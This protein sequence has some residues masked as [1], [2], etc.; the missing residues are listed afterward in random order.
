[1]TFY[2]RASNDA[3]D[4]PT[5]AGTF[6]AFELAPT[7]TGSTCT[8]VLTVS[9]RVSGVNT[10]LAQGP[11]A[12]KTSMTVRFVQ[13]NGWM[14]FNTNLGERYAITDSS[15]TSGKPGVGARL[16]AAGSYFTS[17][18]LGAAD[19]T[20]PSSVV[21]SSV[22][23]A[24]FDTR[25]DL[26]WQGAADDTNGSGIA[27]YQV[28]RGGPVLSNTPVENI[29]DT[30][31]TASQAYVYVIYAF[32]FHGNYSAGTT[33]NVTTAPA[34]MR[35]PRKTGVRPLGLYW[36]ASP[37]NIDLQS[38]NL[39]FSLPTVTAQGRGGS[40]VPLRMSY[41]SQNWRK[42]PGGVWKIGNDVGFGFGW[43]MLAGSLTPVYSGWW[44]V[45]HYLYTDSTGAEYRLD[46]N[47][48]GVWTS[49]E[50]IFLSYDA[51]T[52]RLY[53]PS[54]T[55]WEFGCQSVG[56]EQDAGTLYPTRLVD[57]NGNEIKL[58]YQ[59]GLHYGGVNGSARVSEIEDVRAV[60]V[61]GG[62]Y[63]TYSF[64]Y[65]ND[66]VPHLTSIQ[67]DI[68]TNEYY[69]LSYTQNA[70]LSDPFNGGSFGTTTIPHT[71]TVPGSNLQFLFYY[72]GN[73]RELSKVTMPY[74]GTLEW[75]YEQRTLSGTRTQMGVRYRKLNAQD[76]A[77]TLT[78]D[79]Y[80][81]DPTGDLNRAAHYTMFVKDA[82]AK[83]D[84]G[85]IFNTATDWKLGLMAE[86]Y[87]RELS[88]T[89]GDRR[90]TKATWAQT[91]NGNPYISATEEIIDP[92]LSSEKRSKTEQT[93]NNYGNLI[94]R[95]Q[96]GFYTS[97][98]TPP[99][100]KTFTYTYL[101]TSTYTSRYIYNRPLTVKVQKPGGSLITLSSLG[102]DNYATWPVSNVS[103]PSVLRQHDTANYGTSFTARGNVTRSESPGRAT[104]MRYELTGAV[105]HTSDDYSHNATQT[106]AS[107]HNY[108]VPSAMTAGSLSTSFTWNGYNAVTSTTGP[109]SATASFSYDSY[110]RPA[111]KTA[112]NGQ[113]TNF[114]YSSSAPH[115]TLATTGTRWSK[116][117][118]DGFGR[119]VKAETGYNNGATPVTVSIVETKYTPCGC[120]PIGKLW[121]T[122]LPYAPGG[123]VYWTEHVYDALGRTIQVKQPNNRG[124]TSYSF[125]GPTVTVTDPQGKWKK[126][127][128]D[129]SGKLIKVNEPR[130]GG[131]AD[132]VTDYTYS[133]LGELL[134]VVMARPGLAPNP[135]TVTQTRT[136]VYD[137][138]TRRLT[139][140]THPES[141]TTSFT[142]NGDGSL[143]RK[144]DAK[145]QKHDHYYDSD[146]RLIEVRKLSS[147]SVE[148][149]CQRVN[150]Y[151][152]SNPFDGSFSQNVTGRL[153]AVSRGCAGSGGGGQFIEMY[154]Y[155][156]AGAVLKKRLRVS[157]GGSSIVD[158]DVTYAYGTDGKLSTVLYPGAS[159]P[160]TYTYDLMDRPTK[161]TG[162][163]MMA[164]T[165][166][167]D[168]ARN[169]AYGVAGQVTGMEILKYEADQNNGTWS[170]MYFTEGRTYDELFQLTRIQSLGMD[171]SYTFAST[172]NNG[173]ITR[174]TNNLN[175]EEVDYQYD[176]LNRLISASVS[177]SGGWGQ[178]FVHDGYGNLW[179]QN[180]TKGT[181]PTLS[182]QIDQTNN[183]NW[184][185][186]YDANGNPSGNGMVFDIDNR[187]TE[188]SVYGYEEKEKYNYLADNKRVW[189]KE[190]SGTEY[191][192]FYGVGGQKL[193]TY[194]VSTS[195]SFALNQ[196][197]VNVYFGG[198]LIRA[199]GVA[200]ASDRLG[201]VM[202]RAVAADSASVTSHDY[203][204]YGA[205]IGS[206][207]AGNRDKF[208]TYH[209][210]QST[211]LD[212]ADQRYYASLTGRFMTADPYEAS[213]GT[214][215]P[216]SWNRYPY[217][218]G[219]PINLQDSSGLTYCSVQGLFDRG[220]GRVEAEVFC[221]SNDGIKFATSFY[222]MGSVN[223]ANA[224]Q[225]EAAYYR[226]SAMAQQEFKYWDANDWEL[227]PAAAA[228]AIQALTLNKECLELFGN[229]ETR[230][231]RWNPVTVITSMFIERNSEYGRV[232]FEYSGV[233]A[234]LTR[235]GGIVL[236]SINRNLVQGSSANIT[237]HRDYW[238]R[239]NTDFN[240]NTILH[241]LGHVYNF[242][243]GSGG[244]AIGNL[245][246]ASD[247]F[248]FGKLIEEKCKVK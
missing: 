119:A 82:S 200:V 152:G 131:G 223:I 39:S 226:A 57:T 237:I 195:P 121:K 114:T 36:G 60:S 170:P 234:A 158:K 166:T 93:I 245:S 133:E 85:W 203:F 28:N 241:E 222:D 157:R 59:G 53:F 190:P 83:S 14:S 167:I 229:E 47:S 240:A 42:D 120:T 197:S 117:T 16:L 159:V 1:M 111:S 103:N 155:N 13:R 102:Y 142:Y 92:W 214:S 147:S 205:E 58:R 139:S 178:S 239:G 86:Q 145:G 17:V 189:K 153:A 210:D 192:Y 135:S 232:D 128:N 127:E 212:Y 204:P 148:D 202:G 50:G 185:E 11:I 90:I 174:R 187:M 27:Y 44:V 198:K 218:I 9:K 123:T 37:E 220:N 7:V 154:S 40:A 105:V 96:Y 122:S 49:K 242:V 89:F 66:L 184:G 87:D 141:G 6:Y 175:G 62:V 168:H 25:V 199:D 248:A 63:R 134:T 215:E 156:S 177:G 176:E 191:V 106:T 52:G 137:G 45:N 173:R 182:I 24:I 80:P 208:G 51:A 18:E 144:T 233:G 238:N 113:V 75:E 230:S 221:S 29:A 34:G 169:V 97:G 38:G 109:N 118:V 217:V 64:T 196:V 48:G 35:D 5:P 95:K 225:A 8:L 88:P 181:A 69:A 140:V 146:G 206:A 116:T 231:G 99:L 165:V 201:S 32:D 21:S 151:Y 108:A 244:F 150:Y 136:W 107:T 100:L 124:T 160:Y 20:A 129:A 235:P 33:V 61:G 19:R 207:T 209:R 104:N 43:K 71:M 179:Q 23:S 2:G 70:T 188:I 236:P 149:T 30:T 228:R 246:E 31:V 110:A 77:G 216:S 211:G 84:K 138:G 72:N 224:R 10:I 132:Y 243:R 15:I 213:G 3:L 125:V 115:W 161:M 22:R 55:Y 54:G 73:S 180:V 4:G 56:T 162:P 227:A 247:P 172:T 12:C 91:A 164:P 26:A 171:V 68:P 46:Q 94:D 143:N 126:Y 112:P 79:V 67:A 74:G 163:S 186:S 193:A 41:N 81:G 194:Q 78:Y 76:G 219:D 65:N 130:P 183:R 101:E 98:G